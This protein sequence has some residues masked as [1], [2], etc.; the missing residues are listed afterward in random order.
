M[1][2]YDWT[3]VAACIFAALI[4][5]MMLRRRC[6]DGPVVGFIAIFRFAGWSVLAG[7]YTYVM[8]D[9]GD[10]AISLGAWVGIMLL[11]LG[12]VAVLTSHGKTVRL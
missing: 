3:L 9:T 1:I 12:E 7:R 10:I 11:A 8:L 5:L 4:R 6:E 2:E